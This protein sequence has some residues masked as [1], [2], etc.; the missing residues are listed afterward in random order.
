MDK[1]SI[2]GWIFGLSFFKGRFSGDV[3]GIL[4][5]NFGGFGGGGDVLECV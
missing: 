5:V 1:T 3:W 4:G 2:S